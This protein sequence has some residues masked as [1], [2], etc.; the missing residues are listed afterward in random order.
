M[1]KYYLG[2]NNQ[3]KYEGLKNAI[4][5]VKG[6]TNFEVKRIPVQPSGNQPVS[7]KQTHEFAEQ[8]ISLLKKKV[9]NKGIFVAA[10]G[11]IELFNG[12]PYTFG[13][14]LIEDNINHKKVVTETARCPIPKY[15]YNKLL[16]E[17]SLEL[18]QLV[19]EYANEAGTKQFK[20]A[21]GIF[22]FGKVTRKD[23]F[24]Q[25]FIVAL[26]LLKQKFE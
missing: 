5:K 12:T 19:D 24:E 7:R 1:E 18:G 16:Q 26:S 9:G 10:E 25:A 21:V 23:L 14:V 15:M 22:T 11:G 2:S 8:R 3:S 20:G 6:K 4:I 17:P 13:V